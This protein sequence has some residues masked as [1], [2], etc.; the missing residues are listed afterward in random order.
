M[1]AIRSY[2]ELTGSINN[3][4]ELVSDRLNGESSVV[5]SA[6]DAVALSLGT[7]ELEV[8]KV[9]NNVITSYSIHYTKLYDVEDEFHA[10]T[11]LAS[12]FEAAVSGC[13]SD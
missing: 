9:A 13:T 1:Y 4:V 10:S 2:Y 7:F 3:T 11:T 5:R 12:P 8:Q 6:A